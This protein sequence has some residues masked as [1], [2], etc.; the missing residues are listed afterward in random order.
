[1]KLKNLE[2]NRI[3]FYCQG[4]GLCHC[5]NNSWSFNGDYEKPTFSPSILVRGTLPLTDEEYDLLI[6]GERVVPTPYVCHSFVTD[7]NIQ[8]LN[9]CTHELAGQTVVL[10]DE[11]EWFKD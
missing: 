3:M 11:D 8:Y 10:L 6:K 7:G 5:V 9:D 1:M 4:C 2:D